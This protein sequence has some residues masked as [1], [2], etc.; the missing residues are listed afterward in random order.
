MR[1]DS[2]GKANGFVTFAGVVKSSSCS[3]CGASLW[4]RGPHPFRTERS[5]QQVPSLSR[6]PLLH[7]HRTL[8]RKTV[9]LVGVRPRRVASSSPLESRAGHRRLQ[10]RCASGAETGMTLGQ[11]AAAA[12]S[13]ARVVRVRQRVSSA[14]HGCRG[15]AL[16]NSQMTSVAFSDA[17]GSSPRRL[18]RSPPGQACPLSFKASTSTARPAGHG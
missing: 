4:G 6:V 10:L 3:E 7:A 12:E 9:A 14:S 13:V 17:L 18:P 2:S 16:K 5:L 8:Q 15:C 1:S 11:L